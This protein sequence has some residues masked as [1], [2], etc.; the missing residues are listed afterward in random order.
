MTTA[1]VV[2]SGPN[3]LAAATVLAREGVEVTVIEGAPQLGGGARS[4]EPRLEGLVQDHCAAVHP[5]APGSAF[6]RSLDLEAMGVRWA[7]SPIDAAHPLDDGD[8][9]LLYTSVEQTAELLGSDGRRWA[10][11]FGPSARD[12][13]TL[14]ES[15]MAPMLRVPRHPL[16]LA[17]MGL[18]AGPPPAVVGRLFRT[19]RARAL[20]TGVAAHA[21]QPLTLPL[22]TGIGAGIIIAGHAV[23]WPVIEGGTG[24]FTDAHIAMLRGMGVRFET[25]RTV[26]QLAELPQTDIVLLDVHPH[27]AATILAGDQSARLSR[28]Y[29]RFRPGPAA[30]K[31]DFAVHMGVP[32]RDARVSDAGTV[33]LGG[34][35]AEMIAA[36]R[37]T[38]A[39]RLAERPFVLVGQQAA[40]DPSRARGEI[41]PIY[42]YAH[43]PNGYAG[44]ATELIIRQIER[45][46][47]GFRDRIVAQD[48][49]TPADSE[50]ENPN[51]VGGDILTGA[52]SPMQFLFGPRIDAKPYDTGVPGV[53]L[54]SAATPP[55]PGIHGMGGYNAARR[56]LH[57]LQHGPSRPIPTPRISIE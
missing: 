30:F 7:Y 39:G 3:G 53:Y 1:I 46:A 14:S 28:A 27:T 35:A 20:F 52:K 10:A 24:R 6:F 44:D 56:A 57:R 13:D 25:G 4:V 29:R 26:S 47:P 40:A 34:N 50:R 15:I 45:F 8:A 5:M 23:G 42:S 18:V 32:W 49:R 41:V 43:V 33:H 21:L 31:V 11:A 51:F 22:V 54:C 12:F 17:R 9:A 16:T 38:A 19:E 37:A 36:E 48:V 2:G 55:G